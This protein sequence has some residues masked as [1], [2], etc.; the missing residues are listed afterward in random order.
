MKTILGAFVAAAAVTALAGCGSPGGPTPPENGQVTGTWT[1]SSATYVSVADPN[2]RVD[3]VAQ[4]STVMLVLSL[5]H[6]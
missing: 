2:K 6:I 1:A 4:G 5:I 3:L